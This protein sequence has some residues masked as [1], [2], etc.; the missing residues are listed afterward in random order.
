[1]IEHEKKFAQFVY[2][3]LDDDEGNV[4]LEEFQIEWE[5]YGMVVAIYNLGFM[6][7]KTN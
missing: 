7:A 6:R 5:K 4:T 3:L 1:M 2:D